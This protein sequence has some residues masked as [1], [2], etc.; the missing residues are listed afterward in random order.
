MTVTLTTL[1]HVCTG[2]HM[3]TLLTGFIWLVCWCARE[4]PH[5]LH[6]LCM[7]LTSQQFWLSLSAHCSE[8]TQTDCLVLYLLS[9]DSFS[10]NTHTHTFIESFSSLSPFL[11]QTRPLSCSQ[12]HDLSVTCELALSLL[13]GRN[14]WERRRG[15][16]CLRNQ[17]HMATV[18]WNG[19]VWV[20]P[21][22]NSH[23]CWRSA[24]PRLMPSSPLRVLSG[25]SLSGCSPL[26]LPPA[27]PLTLNCCSCWTVQQYSG[28]SWDLVK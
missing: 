7:S 10:L 13:A 1:I 2:S 23:C 16:V 26:S 14:S 9:L 25:C 15:E 18:W 24:R 11:S 5:F 20:C 22:Y 17:G 27:S 8:H 19:W 3:H 21:L 6:H 28:P 12:I 4:V